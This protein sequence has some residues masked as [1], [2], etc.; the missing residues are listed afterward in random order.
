MKEFL[1]CVYKLFFILLIQFYELTKHEATLTF[2]LVVFCL[3]S[4]LYP[5]LPTLSE[6]SKKENIHKVIKLVGFHLLLKIQFQLYK[7]M[8]LILSNV[9]IKGT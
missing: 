7:T 2:Y 1:T 4:K 9:I 6:I 5:T 8:F 3:F